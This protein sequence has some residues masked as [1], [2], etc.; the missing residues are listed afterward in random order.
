MNYE[1]VP[2][3][4]CSQLYVGDIDIIF[5][6]FV[7]RKNSHNHEDECLVSDKQELRSNSTSPL[8]LQEVDH[9]KKKEE[10]EVPQQ[11]PIFLEGSL[12]MDEN[13]IQEALKTLHG[14]HSLV[15]VGPGKS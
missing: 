4:G 3:D 9:I 13:Q 7:A 15:F 6:N 11:E 12:R 10:E 8:E 5:E 14:T 1:R 2:T